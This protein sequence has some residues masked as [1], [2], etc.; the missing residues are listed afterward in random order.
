MMNTDK[1]WDWGIASVT[2][3]E[4]IAEDLLRHHQGRTPLGLP[5]LQDPAG[6]RALQAYQ[7]YRAREGAMQRLMPPPTAP[8]PAPA[9]QARRHPPRPPRQA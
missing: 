5:D 9:P 1:D 6:L 2:A 3:Q 7:V 8:A 4:W